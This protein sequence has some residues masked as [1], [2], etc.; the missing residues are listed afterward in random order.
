MR[1][2]RNVRWWAKVSVAAFLFL[3]G[4][5]LTVRQAQHDASLG[6]K[7]EVSVQED[8][9]SESDSGKNSIPRARKQGVEHDKL[10]EPPGY[11]DW[12]NYELLERE[13]SQVGPGEQGQAFILPAGHQSQKDQLYKVNGFNALVSDYIA[14]NRTLN[15]LRHPK[16][17]KK[18][19]LNSLPT[20]SVVVPFHNEHWTTLLRT[21]ISAINRSPESL[22]AEVILVDDAS[23]KEFLKDKLDDYVR[24]HLPKVKVLHLTKRSGLIRARLAGAKAAKG[25]VLIFLDS[26]TECTTNWLPPLLD[27]IAQDYRTC[28]CPFIDVI[29]FETFAYRAQDEGAR[30]AFDWELFYKRLPL[31]PKDKENMPE[32]FK[33][34]VMAG[35]LFAISTKFFWELGGYDPG[36][37]IWGGEQYELSFKIWQC[38]GTMVDA[39]CSRI[40]HIYR[41]FAPFPNPGMGDFVGRNYRRVAEVWM[42]EYAEFIY[43]RRPHYRNIDPGDLSEQKAIR[44]KLQCRPFRWF[45]EE[46][47]PDLVKV[48][49]PVEPPD[50]ASGK[51]QSIV[52]SNL[53]VDTRYKRHG[54]RFGMQECGHGGEQSF[55]LTWHKDIRPGKRSVCWDVSSGDAQAPVLLYN[56]HGM[57]GNQMWRYDPDKKWLVH[58]GNPR[59]LDCN[60]GNKELFV[61]MCDPNRDTQKWSFEK[62]DAQRLAKWDQAG[63]GL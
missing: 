52:D 28:V 60:P 20:A 19:Y 44:Q 13:K 17:Q 14:L 24:A 2:R 55:H 61:A 27:P 56:C 6:D 34:P 35:G 21:A 43:K 1:L 18:V 22:L 11:K 46:V 10:P 47:A 57:G 38:G 62:Y 30:G 41:K 8:E 45:M 9:G 4:T 37:D 7:R 25:D 3:L 31:L 50:F 63:P 49:P 54:D 32:P 26:H 39:P 23:T 40:G 53:C 51:I 12:N 16:C 42:D 5:Y 58:G 29:D 33:S 59:C 15:D 36:L 48:Y